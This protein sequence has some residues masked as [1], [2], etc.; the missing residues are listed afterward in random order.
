MQGHNSRV[1]MLSFE[2]V[3]RIG[4]ERI[5]SRR[6]DLKKYDFMT[7]PPFGW[8]PDEYIDAKAL[9][10]VWLLAEKFEL[11]TFKWTVEVTYNGFFLPKMVS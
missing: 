1:P 3:C 2:M 7:D 5:E 4:R 8:V 11:L 9:N 6:G 10:S